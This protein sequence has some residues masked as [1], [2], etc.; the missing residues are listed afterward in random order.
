MKSTGTQ[1]PLKLNGRGITA[2]QNGK[3]SFAP[4]LKQIVK[5]LL[6]FDEAETE[7]KIAPPPR[8]PLGWPYPAKT[9]KTSAPSKILS[10]DGLNAQISAALAQEPPAA[11][12]EKLAARAI[13]APQENRRAPLISTT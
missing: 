2:L 9:R 3:F 1:Y 6:E 11:V 8:T 7:I 12:V 13:S 10:L 5:G 4:R